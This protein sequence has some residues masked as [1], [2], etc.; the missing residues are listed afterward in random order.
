[1]KTSTGQTETSTGNIKQQLAG[2]LIVAVAVILSACGDSTSTEANVESSNNS[3]ATVYTGPAPS[4]ADI[5]AFKLEFWDKLSPDNRCG[6]C[7]VEN[8]D[9]PAFVHKGNVNTAY[10]EAIQL[11]D[12][13]NYANSLVV[14]QVASGHN[15]W[16]TD[17]NVCATIIEGYIALWKGGEPDATGR[18]IVLN[19]PPIKDPGDSRNFPLTAQDNSPNSFEERL[20]PLLT[21]VAN[22][23]ECHAETSA[24]AISPFFAS[25]DVNVAYEAA[26]A[27]INLDVPADSRMVIRLREELHNC[28][29]NDCDSD[30]QDI[31][32]QI[33]LMAGAITPTE[34]DTSLIT[35]KALTLDDATI[36]SGGSRYETN[37]IALWEF[38]TGNG[39]QTFDTSGVDPAID[40]TFSGSVDW[41]LGDGI[42]IINGKAQGST[43]NSKKLHDLIKAT[44]EYSIEA[45]LVPGNVSQEDASIISY[46]AGGGPRNFTMEQDLYN[47][48]LLNRTELSDPNGGPALSTADADEDLQ[49][50][51]Q[52]VVMNFDPVNGRQIFVNGV[53]TDDPETSAG[54]SLVDWN[55]NY[56]FVL[57][58][59]PNGGALWKGKIRMAA[60]HNRALSQ[61]QI[62]QNFAVGVG[63]KYFMLFSVA[64]RLGIPDSYILFHVEQFD[65]YSY[66]FNQPRFINLD[67]NWVPTSD[68]TIKGLRIGINGREAITAQAFANMDETV[69]STDYDFTNN[70][71]FLSDRGTI[72]PLEKSP[73][74]LDE[75]FLTFEE[76][77]NL[78]P[79]P[80][81]EDDP[82]APGAPPEAEAVSEIGLRTFEEI[83]ATMSDVTGV[84]MTNTTVSAIYDTYR[85]QLPVT[86]DINTF[87]PSHQMAVAQLAMS[88]CSVLVDT[89][90][91]Y[92]AG[93]NFNETAGTAFNTPT[94]KEDVLDPL[95]TAIMN[96]DKNDPARSLR[97]PIEETTIR[98]MLGAET[99]QD[100]D[101]DPGAADDYESLIDCMARCP[102]DGIGAAK[103]PIYYEYDTNGNLIPASTTCTATEVTDQ[104]T[105]IRTR[106]IV[107]AACAAML[108]SAAMLIQ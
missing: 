30:A 41:V 69:N 28:W 49:A 14:Q 45:W 7:H 81:V 74:Q 57:G 108:G 104:N 67:E 58:N 97:T 48:T 21:G 4:T 53:F 38:K 47:Y 60:I 3:G 11:I 88:Y 102:T 2:L 12:L 35:S 106:E 25:D 39:T 79:N 37:T 64:E 92:F 20:Y 43:T 78:P 16:V 6:Q 24:T 27:K 34:V 80:F 89:D 26:K 85:Q 70:G 13:D 36:A 33:A 54:R 100:L 61:A 87:L 105:D 93:F 56:A 44:G 31:Q 5:Q 83:H 46:S 32:D 71:Q 59:E 63:K 91:G 95:L 84:A 9:P 75:F 99:V 96:V 18:Q 29:T 42:E 65:N 101:A 68:I 51:L 52:H 77:G 107:K 62:D 73:P 19:A 76:L 8:G 23:N 22:C 103:C 98:D 82:V 72:I 17:N 55:P 50:S 86:E 15:C 10:L 40:L 94:K 1:M 66:L 90:P